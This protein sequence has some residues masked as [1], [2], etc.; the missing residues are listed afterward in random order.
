MIVGN[1]NCCWILDYFF[2]TAHNLESAE[3]RRS[4]F[5]TICA[6]ALV[7]AF[8]QDKA[9]ITEQMLRV[10]DG[11]RSV[12]TLAKVSFMGD[13]TPMIGRRLI[14]NQIAQEQSERSNK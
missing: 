10:P 5:T 2:Y 13:T 7:F 9:L 6:D 4:E 3:E 14:K 1:N 12:E 11:G 8:N